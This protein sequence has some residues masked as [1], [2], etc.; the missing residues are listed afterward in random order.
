MISLEAI[1]DAVVDL[2]YEID[3]LEGCIEENH[4]GIDWNDGDIRKSDKGIDTI[5]HIIEH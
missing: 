3:Y 4:E 2:D 5:D 1:R